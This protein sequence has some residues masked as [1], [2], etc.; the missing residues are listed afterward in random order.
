MRLRP[1]PPRRLPESPPDLVA[2][3]PSPSPVLRPQPRSE[4][5]IRRAGVWLPGLAVMGSW[6]L[7]RGRRGEVL[8]L[9]V[10]IA[11]G[12]CWPG[13]PPWACP[14]VSITSW[15]GWLLLTVDMADS[16]EKGLVGEC[17]VPGGELARCGGS[18]QRTAGDAGAEGAEGAGLAAEEPAMLVALAPEMSDITRLDGSMAMPPLQAVAG[19]LTQRWV[20]EEW[21]KM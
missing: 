8:V 14:S 9:V 5:V 4:V 19:G 20:S 7:G 13:V 1:P 11:P 12:W 16:L 18:W 6:G 10:L 3:S 17:W 21:F 2:P 15:S